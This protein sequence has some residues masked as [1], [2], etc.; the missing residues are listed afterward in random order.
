MHFMIVSLIL[1][2][3]ATCVSPSGVPRIQDGGPKSTVFNFLPRYLLTLPQ[4]KFLAVTWDKMDFS[5]F[6]NDNFDVKEWVNSALRA[7]DDKIPVDAHASTL[8]MKLQLFIQE[9][10]N[11][12]EETSVQAVNNIPRV[13]REIDNV[14]HEASLLREQMHMVKEDIK[15]VEE[16][17]A[18]SMKMLMELDT[19]KSHMQAASQ[20]LQ[21]A[22]NW[23]TLSSDVDKVFESGDIIAISDKLVGMHKSLNV[24]QDV[25][26]YAERRRMLE[27]LKNRLEA[28]LS[29]KI[30]AAFNNHCLDETKSY[31]KIFTAIDR[32][33]QLQNYYIR[34]HKTKLQQAWNNTRTEDPN[35]PMVDWLATFYDVI[36][37][38][39]H[40]EVTWC[41]QVFPEPGT[42]LCVLLTQALTHL[43]PSLPQCITEYIKDDDNVLVR[44]IELRQVSTRFALGLE[45]A[46][47][48]Q[49]SKC[50]PAS[51]TTLVDAVFSPYTHYLLDYPSLQQTHLSSRLQGIPLRVEGFLE[52]AG[53][54]AESVDHVFCLADEAVNHC[55]LLTDGYA[56]CCLCQ[57]LEEFFSAYAGSLGECITHLRQQCR[58]DQESSPLPPSEEMHEDWTLFQNAFRLIQICGDLM[59]RLRSH[60]R[61]LRDMLTSCGSDISG[62]GTGDRS[63]PA[64][65]FKWYNYLQKERPTDFNTLLEFIQKLQTDDGNSDVTILQTVHEQMQALN[66]QA[67]R[68]AFD[69]TFVPIRQQLDVMPRLEVWSAVSAESGSAL[70]SELPIF[71]L[72]PQGYITHIG[73]HLLTLPQQLEP[74][75]TQENMALSTAMKMGKLPYPPDPGSREEDPASQWLGSIARGTMHT[76]VEGILRLHQL[77]AYSCRQMIADIEYLCNVLEA[78]EV[79]PTPDLKGID[80]LLRASPDEFHDIAAEHNVQDRIQIALSGIRKIR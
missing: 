52:M 50:N 74:F 18:Q 53:L 39:W 8:V 58:L 80:L 76:Y 37:S 27:G 46:I 70:R 31:V 6:S 79:E 33:D 30:V 51:I 1:R 20:G 2:Q 69:I 71:S 32:L 41:S 42:V 4:K 49:Q 38:T 44:L 34:C 75:I 14:Q 40:T 13:V 17:T 47:N 68:L 10:N 3:R 16:N 72:S 45:T 9:V 60:D 15:K 78:L 54:M 22:D 21:E 19:V 35:R 23:T 5:K 28:L 57:V 77:T 11:A 66:E 36:L 65:P 43:T 73:D 48:Q 7:R 24:L 25:P 63:R 55:V 29:P 64:R 67:H 56:A 59:I 26:D 62:K 12:L 61:N